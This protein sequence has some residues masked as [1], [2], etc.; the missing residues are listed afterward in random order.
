MARDNEVSICRKDSPD[1]AY[2]NCHT[3]VTLPYDEIGLIEAV[4]ENGE[5]TAIIKDGR[6]VLPGLEELNI[7]IDKI[8]EEK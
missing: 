8:L 2:F 7:Y 6:F 1:K 4:K 3:D 5:R